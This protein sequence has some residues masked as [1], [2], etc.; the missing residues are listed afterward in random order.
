MTATT[1]KPI[2][3]PKPDPIQALREIAPEWARWFCIDA[4][5]TGWM[6]SSRGTPNDCGHWEPSKKWRPVPLVDS[7]YFGAGN[8][9]AISLRTH[10]V[11]LQSADGT[12]TEVTR[13]EWDV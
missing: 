9:A 3:R 6:Q 7:R 11:H 13:A 4:H 12:I 10:S 1:A 2:T 8:V 5:G